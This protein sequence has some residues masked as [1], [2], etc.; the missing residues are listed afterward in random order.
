M[1]RVH[2][3]SV[4]VVFPTSKVLPTNRTHFIFNDYSKYKSHK[5]ATLFTQ[6]CADLAHQEFEKAFQIWKS[7]DF[8]GNSDPEEISE[9]T[10][11]FISQYKAKQQNFVFRHA[12]NRGLP[13]F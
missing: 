1:L 8:E 3:I 2:G 11:I 9:A 10:W 7:I 12:L 6:I 13:S 5:F 4:S